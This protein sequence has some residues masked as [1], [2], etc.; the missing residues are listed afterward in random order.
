MNSAEKKR[1]WQRIYRLN[2]EKKILRNEK[3]RAHRK[4]NLITVRIAARAWNKS[5]RQLINL[6]KLDR[7]CYDCGGMFPPE[8]TD[9]DHLPGAIKKFNIANGSRRR[10]E[11]VLEEI[12]KCQLVC[13][14]CHRI[15][16][17]K[18]KE[19]I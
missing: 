2:P 6:I 19:E 17:E 11:V 1:E 8:A 9:W 14:C 10:L 3:A 7:P 12:S 15:R 4:A 18:R 13:A 16:T 5:R